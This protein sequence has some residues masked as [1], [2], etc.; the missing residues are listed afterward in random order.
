MEKLQVSPSIWIM[1]G[2][3]V[4]IVA[5]FLFLLLLVRSKRRPSDEGWKG[6]FYYNPNDTA[7]FVPKRYRIGYTLNFANPWSWI[8]MI[9]VFALAIA[10]LIYSA[11]FL[12]NLPK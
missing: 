5:S 12:H 11:A 4:L 3:I 2:P 6:V 7:L 8:L 9:I 1:L 10:P